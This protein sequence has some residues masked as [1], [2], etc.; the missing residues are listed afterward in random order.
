MGG[1]RHTPI[2]VFLGY[3]VCPICDSGRDERKLSLFRRHLY[4]PLILWIMAYLD[5]IPGTI[6]DPKRPFD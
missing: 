5:L 1:E 4:K 6:N 2:G 3:I